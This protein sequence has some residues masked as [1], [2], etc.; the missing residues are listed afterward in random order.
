MWC[1]EMYLG[2]YTVSYIDWPRRRVYLNYSLCTM[3]LIDICYSSSF[4]KL[5]VDLSWFWL[6]KQ[7]PKAD[8]Y[9][10]IFGRTNSMFVR[11]YWQIVRPRIR[12]EPKGLSYICLVDYDS[13][14]ECQINLVWHNGRSMTK[15]YERPKDF[16]LSL[17]TNILK[18]VY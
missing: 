10:R 3:W 15:I 13:D 2:L 16:C 4:D 18:K 1:D 14:H 17:K 8:N 11:Q 5:F 6:H 9:N 7:F 12:R